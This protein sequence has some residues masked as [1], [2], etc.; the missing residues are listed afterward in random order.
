MHAELKRIFL[1]SIIAVALMVAIMIFIVSYMQHEMVS[2][3]PNKLAEKRCVEQGG[4]WTWG[5]VYWCK[6][7]VGDEGK[8]CTDSSQC[9]DICRTD[10]YDGD[11]GVCTTFSGGCDYILENEDVHAICG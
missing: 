10:T 1:V 8:S 7:P 5:E 4:E 11:A 3:M 9:E 2:N 6:M